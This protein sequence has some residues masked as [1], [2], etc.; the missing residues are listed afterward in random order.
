ML[1]LHIMSLSWPFSAY[2][3]QLPA[4]LEGTWVMTVGEQAYQGD[5]ALAG[6]L[7]KS[8]AA[9]DLRQIR[10]LLAGVI[11]APEGERPDDWIGLIAPTADEPTK[12]QLRA[13]KLQ[14]AKAA[15]PAT[16]APGA[17]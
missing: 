2:L 14:L 9:A 7:K 11:A 15:K 12:A 13:L 16:L 10:G 3:T 1:L 17:P 5:E 8:G 6:L 4:N